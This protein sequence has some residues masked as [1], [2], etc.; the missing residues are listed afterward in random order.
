MEGGLNEMVAEALPATALIPVG[1]PGTV[2]GAVG[3]TEFEAAEDELVPVLVVIL[4][5]KV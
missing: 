5:V 4:A 2:A 3:V 1:I